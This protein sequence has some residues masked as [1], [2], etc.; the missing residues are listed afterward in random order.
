MSYVIKLLAYA[1]GA[2]CKGA[3]EFVI[4]FDHEAFNGRGF[5]SH[6]PDIKRAKKFDDQGAAFTF[7]KRTP[8][9]KPRRDDGQPNRPMTSYTI[10]ILRM[11]D[12]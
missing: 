1:N 6:S 3:G 12:A 10:E 2:Y 7:W 8:M 11:E 5:I 4:Y 9:C